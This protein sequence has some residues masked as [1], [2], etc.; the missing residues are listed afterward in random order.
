MVGGYFPGGQMVKKSAC[1]T[2]YP[3]SISGSERSAGG[4][5]DHPLLYICLKN[6]MDRGAWW[7]TA[8]GVTKSQIQ[9]SMHSVGTRLYIRKNKREQ[10][11]YGPEKHRYHSVIYSSS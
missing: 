2:G 7:A 5:H 11:V 10:V 1:N 4:G 9:L 3:G 8:H 6:P